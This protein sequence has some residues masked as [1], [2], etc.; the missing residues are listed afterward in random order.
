MNIETFSEALT[1]V[2]IDN[3]CRIQ[4]TAL[5]KTLEQI[6]NFHSNLQ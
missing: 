5:W 4:A 3:P 1:K 2:Y 6:G